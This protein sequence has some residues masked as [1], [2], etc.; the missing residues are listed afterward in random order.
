MNTI[1]NIAGQPDAQKLCNRCLGRLFGK[2]GHNLDNPTRGK[3]TRLLLHLDE[4]IS[5]KIIDSKSNSE[6]LKNESEKYTRA[7]Q[8]LESFNFNDPEMQMICNVLGI[9]RNIQNTLKNEDKK[10]TKNQK[11]TENIIRSLINPKLIEKLTNDNSSCNLCNDIFNEL[12]KF[13]E[14]VCDATKDYE[15]NDFLIGCKIDIDQVRAEEELWSNLGTKSPELLKSEFNRELGKLVQARLMKDVNFETPDITIIVDTRYDITRLQIASLFI[16]GRYRKFSRDIPQTKWPCK[17]CWG[18]GCKKCNGTGKVYQTSVEELIAEKVMEITKG[19]NHLFHGM[20]RED[21]EVRMLGNGRPFILEITEP[22]VR[23]IDLKE[24]EKDI[25]VFT[26][27][28][29][30]I[31]NLR[32]S[33]H[34][35][36]REI[37]AAKPSKTYEVKINFEKKINIQKLKDIVSTFTGQIIKQRTPIRV[38]HRRADLVRERKVLGMRISEVSKD[39][40]HAIFEITGESGLYIK[41][42]VTGDSERTLPSISSELGLQCTVQGLD[43]VRI[44]DE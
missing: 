29:V 26:K 36:V 9:Q 13:T 17:S 44:N 11:E 20:G 39:G 27:D 22:K 18:R 32:F 19:K 3:A 38:S 43:V 8:M 4:T 34:R 10:Q 35:E 12:P 30:E 24:I 5:S 31:F 28:K 23:N 42:L 40:I 41:E 14:L 25:N 6:E 2:L 15:F 21:I 16:Y 1:L 37:K 7:N 33:T